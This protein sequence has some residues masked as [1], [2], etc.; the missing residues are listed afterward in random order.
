VK[1]AIWIEHISGFTLSLLCDDD[2]R[3]IVHQ[4]L[5]AIYRMGVP[6]SECKVKIGRPR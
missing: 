4:A 3:M 6:R 2:R 5:L 1:R